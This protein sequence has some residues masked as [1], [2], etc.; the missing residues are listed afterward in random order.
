MR[1]VQV[2]EGLTLLDKEDTFAS[3]AYSFAGLSDMM[4]QFGQQLSG[5]SGI[6]LV[7]LFGQSPAGLSSTGDADI[8]LYYDNINAQQE[9]KFRTGWETVLKV[10]WRST[11]G[12]DAPKD[13]EFTF[14]PLWQ[15]SAMDK[16]NIA[17]TNAETISGAHQEGLVSTATAMKELRQSAGDTGVFSNITDEDILKAEEQ[18][19]EPPMPEGEAPAPQAEGD[20]DKVPLAETGLNEYPRKPVVKDAFSKLKAWLAGDAKEF[21]EN[22]HPRKKDGK[23]GSGGGGGESGF[24]EKKSGSSEKE[25]SKAPLRERINEAEAKLKKLKADA[26][27]AQSRADTAPD[28]AEKD[29][30]SLRDANAKVKAYNEQAE[31]YNKLLDE[32]DETKKKPEAKKSEPKKNPKVEALEAEKDKAREAISKNRKDEKALEKFEEISNKIDELKNEDA[33]AVI[34]KKELAD[35]KETHETDNVLFHGTLNNDLTEFK[36]PLSEENL[37]ANYGQR[38]GVGISLSPTVSYSEQYTSK[39][40]VGEKIGQVFKIIPEKGSIV[41]VFNDPQAIEKAATKLGV[42]GFLSKHMASQPNLQLEQAIKKKYPEAGKKE[43]YSKMVEA[44]IKG[45][46]VGGDMGKEYL[47]HDPSGLAVFNEAGERVDAG[48]KKS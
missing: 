43:I 34:N 30:K 2:N 17:K 5:A 27:R 3:T 6:P 23:F 28:R 19:D 12:V 9:A 37:S 13:L 33:K 29:P 32:R 24:S 31:I 40:G 41:D 47:M 1:S 45:F 21:K 4:L 8:R 20:T 39:N 25:E 18:A 35:L 16:A 22:E 36:D 15:M 14:A 26:K 38:R 44:G 10:L 7:R 46:A 11:Y 42:E 48:K